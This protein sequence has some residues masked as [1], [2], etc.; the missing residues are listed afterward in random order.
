MSKKILNRIKIVIKENDDHT[1]HTFFQDWTKLV[2][3]K[4]KINIMPKV[5][6]FDFLPG[7]MFHGLKLKSDDTEIIDNNLTV[8]FECDF[9]INHNDIT[10]KFVVDKW[11]NKM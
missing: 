4:E 8:N 7:Y 6:E 11:T 1:L 5:V 2:D 3:M 10:F 9:A